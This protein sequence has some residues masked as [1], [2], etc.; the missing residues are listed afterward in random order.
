MDAL[1]DKFYED[2][3]FA[4]KNKFREYIAKYLN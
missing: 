2:V 4:V 3:D 1:L